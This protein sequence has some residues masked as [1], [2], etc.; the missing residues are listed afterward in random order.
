VSAFL[1]LVQPYGIV[2][3]ARTGNLALKRG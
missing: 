1:N 2:E 3:M